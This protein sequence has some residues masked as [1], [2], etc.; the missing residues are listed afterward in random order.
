MTPPRTDRSDPSRMASGLDLDERRIAFRADAMFSAALAE[1]WSIVSPKTD[2]IVEGFWE[3]FMSLR[4]TAATVDASLLPQI[5]AKQRL[6]QEHKYTRPVDQEWIDR[7]AWHGSEMARTGVPVAMVIGCFATAHSRLLQ[8]LCEGVGDPARLPRLLDAAV[9][10]AALES[11]VVLSRTYLLRRE[12]AVEASRA[13]GESLSRQIA[14]AVEA[15]TARS[16]GVRAQTGA[17]ASHTRAMLGKAAEVA[18]A[19]DQSASA[20][21]DAA[22][23][24]AGLIRAIEEARREVESATVVATRAS[25]QAGEAMDNAVVLSDHAQAIE[26]IV[27][28]IRDIAGQTN[29]LA[30][31]ATIEAARA[32]DAGR[33]FAVVAQ[34]VKSLAAQ[35]ARATDDIAQQISAIQAATRRSV[36]ANGSIR[37]TVVEVHGSAERI[38]DAIDVQ[39][40]TVT[41]ITGSV[42]ETALSANSM[43]EIIAG[44]R[45][46]TEQVA[47]EIDAVDT[48]FAGVD[49]QLV[50]LQGSVT[51]FVETIAA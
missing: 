25:T 17:A 48:G 49:D 14:V 39:A 38:R 7:A 22:Q 29:L 18:A 26:S 36:A 2:W 41:A 47:D 44:I 11:E 6:Y 46:A 50:A 42:D 13:Q 37:D 12:A 30:L 19:A 4:E 9:R 23:T 20:M 51:S 16:R 32:G 43:T 33:G 21:R 15:A 34:E 3:R 45:A 31:N 1:V 40:E 10:V 35:T 8:A 5:I 27:S 28:L 24:A